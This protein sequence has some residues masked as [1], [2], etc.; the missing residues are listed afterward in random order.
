MT[1]CCSVEWIIVHMHTYRKIIY[2]DNSSMQD[3]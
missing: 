1:K 2:Y 3:R